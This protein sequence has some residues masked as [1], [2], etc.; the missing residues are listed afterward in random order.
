MGLL[1]D[2][3][4]T[5]AQ[6]EAW[7]R[8]NNAIQKETEHKIAEQRGEVEPNEFNEIKT[9]KESI[10]TGGVDGKVEF[11]KPSDKPLD[12]TGKLY[13]IIAIVIAIGGIVILAIRN[14]WF[15]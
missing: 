2:F 10:K 8:A 13:I 12:F 11:D 3:V 7:D 14:G 6:V 1:N 15:S 4:Q 9:F 5:N